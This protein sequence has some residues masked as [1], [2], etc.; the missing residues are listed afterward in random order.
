[1]RQFAYHQWTVSDVVKHFETDIEVGLTEEKATFLLQKNG[2][3]SLRKRKD[4]SALK[5]GTELPI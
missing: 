1:M 5:T 2:P 4:I 3:N